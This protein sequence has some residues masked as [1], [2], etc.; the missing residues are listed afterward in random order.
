LGPPVAGRVAP[1]WTRAVLPLVEPMRVSRAWMETDPPAIR[2]EAV[3][4]MGPDGPLV[5]MGWERPEPMPAPRRP[6][7]DRPLVVALDPGH[8]G[9]DPGAERGGMTEAD[10]MLGFAR[11]L[12]ERLRRAGHEVVLT[13][14]ADEFVSLRGRPAMA[15][16]AGADVMISL[17]ADA[18][19]GGGAEGATVYTLSD[20]PADALSAELAARQGTDDLLLGVELPEAGDEIAQVLLE[21]A[22]AETA[23]RSDALADAL[24]GA[25]GGAGLRLHKRPRLSGA[26]TVLKAPDIPAVLLELGFMSSDADLANLRDPAWRARM[27][28]AVVAGVEAWAEADAA[29]ALRLRR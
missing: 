4:G 25:I 7:G 15:R 19:A 21:L 22:R 6:M 8:G 17:H 14:E 18:V 2:V 26:F 13:R 11:E 12:S 16:R 9:I 27:A 5:V 29:E 1:G 24:A 20:A 10:L 3:P 28:D 23:P